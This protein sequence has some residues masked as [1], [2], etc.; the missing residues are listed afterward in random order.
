MHSG[1]TALLQTG[2]WGKERGKRSAAAFDITEKTGS[3]NTE[4]D[5]YCLWKSDNR[6]LLGTA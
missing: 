5:R 3:F 4:V 6:A 1:Q 2:V